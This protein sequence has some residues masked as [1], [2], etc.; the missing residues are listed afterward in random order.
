ML[1]TLRIIMLNVRLVMKYWQEDANTKCFSFDSEH[2]QLQVAATLP[3]KFKNCIFWR[4]HQNS[5]KPPPP[6]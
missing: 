5:C 1:E 6:L 4:N 2:D 3:I